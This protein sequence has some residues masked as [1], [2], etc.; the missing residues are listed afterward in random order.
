MLRYLFGFRGTALID[1][2]VDPAG[3]RTGAAEIA[4][5]LDGGRQSVLDVDASGT[6]DALTDGVMILRDLFGFTGSALVEDALAPT[7]G[8]TDPDEIA[9]LLDHF[10]PDGLGVAALKGPAL[11]TQAA[12]VGD[13]DL[14]PTAP[15]AATEGSTFG[16]SP[17]AERSP[18]YAEATDAVMTGQTEPPRWTVLHRAAWWYEPPGH[19]A[20][21]SA[22]PKL[23]QAAVDLLLADYA[24]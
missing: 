4:A 3:S 13:G 19:T 16:R 6:A 2:A 21:R 18:R 22:T 14:V 1:N 11:A 9:A 24:E 8:R 5:F 7:A 23:P 10:D 20:R 17:R 12:P 15:L